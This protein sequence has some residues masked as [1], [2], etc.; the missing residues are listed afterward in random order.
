MAKEHKTFFLTLDRQR[1]LK[2]NGVKRISRVVRR[3]EGHKKIIKEKTVILTARVAES[4]YGRFVGT[5]NYEPGLIKEDMVPLGE[6]IE[7]ALIEWLVSTA[8]QAKRMV[9]F[10]S[11]H[12][13]EENK[14]VLAGLRRRRKTG[15]IGKN[16]NSYFYRAIKVFGRIQLEVNLPRPRPQLF[17]K[18]QA[19]LRR[20]IM[21]ADGGIYIYSE[22]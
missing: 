7:E 13:F 12:S 20:L 17:L 8:F 15:S 9:L 11:D 19:Y 4:I 16:S 6:Y 2:R 5:I 22:W 10:C 1:E 18:R 14:D 3:E 21:A